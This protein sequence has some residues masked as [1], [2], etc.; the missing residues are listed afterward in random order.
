MIFRPRTQK[1]LRIPCLF[2]ALRVLVPLSNGAD[3]TPP[4]IA[5][6]QIQAIYRVQVA[7]DGHLLESVVAAIRQ[8]NI[9]DGAVLMGIGSL[10]ECAYHRSK[11]LGPDNADEFYTVKGAMELLNLDGTITGGKPHLHITFSNEKGAFGGHL[12]D[13]RVLRG[14]ELVIAKFSA[15][16]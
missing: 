16:R 12:D 11:S 10:Q 13:C 3:A 2:A 7:R 5:G 15:L 4:K 8:N 1:W 9:Q 6:G 14:V